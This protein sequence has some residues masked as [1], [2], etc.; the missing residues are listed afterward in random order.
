MCPYDNN[1]FKGERERSKNRMSTESP[2]RELRSLTE[3]M[4]TESSTDGANW[5]LNRWWELRTQ[6]DD[7]NW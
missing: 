5:E 1:K 4:R 3:M 2:C 7:G 6:A